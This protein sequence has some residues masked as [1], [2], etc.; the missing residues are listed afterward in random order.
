[1]KRLIAVLL[2][3]C[4]PSWGAIAFVQKTSNSAFGSNSCVLTMGQAT[5]AGNLLVVGVWYQENNITTT[6]VSSTH[7]TLAQWTAARSQCSFASANEIWF[8]TN[9]TGG[10]TVITQSATGNPI[11]SCYAYEFSGAASSVVQ[12]TSTAIDNSAGGNPMSGSPITPTN[13]GDVCLGAISTQDSSNGPFSSSNWSGFQA[14]TAMNYNAMAYTLPGVT[15]S[16]TPT[17]SGDTTATNNNNNA[18]SVCFLPA[19][20]GGGGSTGPNYFGINIQ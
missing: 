10:D 19:A 17:F 14:N 3:L 8:K 2:F 4:A 12:D 16:V 13:S 1:V 20:G 15:T 5:G 6:G 7:D 9:I 11:V 18:S